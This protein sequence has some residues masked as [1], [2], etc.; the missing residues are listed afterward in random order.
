MP[1]G[2]GKNSHQNKNVPDREHTQILI[3]TALRNLNAIKQFRLSPGE[4]YEICLL[5]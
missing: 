1:V 3:K 5:S 2:W 4:P